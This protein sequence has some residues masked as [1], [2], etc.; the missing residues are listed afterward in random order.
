M[1]SK[2]FVY[3]RTHWD[4]R[5]NREEE[6]WDC[7]KVTAGETG[8]NDCWTGKKESLNRFGIKLANKNRIQIDFQLKFCLKI[9]ETLRRS[10]GTSIIS[11]QFHPL[12]KNEN[13]LSLSK[14][15]KHK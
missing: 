2:F 4:L 8:R 1:K 10:D 3:S 5:G 15:E 12:A 6:N 7:E 9:E 14:H 11:I 13:N